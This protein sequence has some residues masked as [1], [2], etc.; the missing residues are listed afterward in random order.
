MKL[1]PLIL[2][3]FAASICLGLV[4]QANRGTKRTE[5]ETR[6]PKK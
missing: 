6:R 3:L 1:I 4:A 5:N 2:L